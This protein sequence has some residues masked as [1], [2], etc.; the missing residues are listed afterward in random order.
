VTISQ[1]PNIFITAPDNIFKVCENDTLRLGV[2]GDTFS[3]FIWSTGSTEP[4]TLI[5][6]GGTYSVTVVTSN[7][8]TLEAEKLIQETPT[9]D[10]IVLAESQP[11]AQSDFVE[12]NSGESVRLT[13]SGGLSNVIWRPG[14]S[15]SDSTT[16][17]T[18]ATPLQDV[19]YVVRGKDFN[20]CNV[21]GSIMI[22]VLGSSPLELIKPKK[23]FS[24]NGDSE[25]QFWTIDNILSFPQCTVTIY[26]DNPPASI[27]M[28]SSAMG[29]MTGRPALL[30]Y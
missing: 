12:I 13:A 14:F 5:E 30:H 4:T 19:V 15:L 11:I 3:S 18:I 7:G 28:L 21:Q 6:G 24:P 9:S 29:S 16:A 27:T 17:N 23:Y 20:G 8:C 2:S 25:N 10:V 22:K 1:G 26:N